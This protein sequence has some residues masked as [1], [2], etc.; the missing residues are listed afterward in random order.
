VISK[1]VF[2]SAYIKGVDPSEDDGFGEVWAD[3]HKFG[4]VLCEFEHS[5]AWVNS[6]AWSPNGFRLAFT[7]QGSTI[8]FVQILAGAAPVVQTLELDC[9]PFLDMD[10]ID[11]GTVVAAG[12]SMN[13][14]IFKS[15]GDDSS[16]TWEVN[17]YLD[18]KSESTPTEAKKSTTFDKSKTMFAD[19]VSRGIK[20]GADGKTM[21]ILTKHKNYITCLQ[22]F[23]KGGTVKRI[24][25]S[26]LD[27]RVLFWNV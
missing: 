17:D 18:K 5:K 12:F 22:L 27:G 2:F 20:L 16:P 15:S 25:T 8:H 19:S 26:A 7:G 4:E 21:E 10:F 14:T 6:V 23:G 13:P 11:D 24:T 1:P 3:Q 9:L